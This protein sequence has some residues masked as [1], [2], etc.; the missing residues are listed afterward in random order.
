MHVAGYNKMA[1]NSAVMD[2]SVGESEYVITPV[3]T[4]RFYII[5]LFI[6]TSN[7]LKTLF[8]CCIYICL[9]KNK[10]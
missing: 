4:H 2:F 3:N 6:F 9:L 8:Q 1:I 5:S 10:K 7:M